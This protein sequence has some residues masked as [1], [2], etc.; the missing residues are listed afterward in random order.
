M[1]WPKQTACVE[2]NKCI[3]DFGWETLRKQTTCTTRHGWKHV[4]I[5]LK[6]MGSKGMKRIHLAQDM[7]QW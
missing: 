2:E 4:K 5:I 7:D 1:R 3:H 6:E